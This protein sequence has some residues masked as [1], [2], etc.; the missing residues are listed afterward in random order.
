VTATV[1]AGACIDP[2]TIAAYV[3]GTL[4]PAEMREVEGHLADCDD[5]RELATGT[6][7]V[8]E[9]MDADDR[10]GATRRRQAWM[11]T[12]FLVLAAALAVVVVAPRLL[13]RLR[14]MPDSSALAAA[15]GAKRLT[16]GRLAGGFAY[17][18]L[19]GDTRAGD[20]PGVAPAEVIIAAARAE[21]ALARRKD[22]RSLTAYGA[23]QLLT[24]N[25]D[26][27]VAALEEAQA[28]DGSDVAVLIDL[29]SAYYEKSRRV[30]EDQARILLDKAMNAATEAT[31]LNLESPEA[32]FNR[33]LLQ[34][35]RGNV[36]DSMAAW[37][38]F[39]AVERDP[40][41]LEEG[42]RHLA[43]LERPRP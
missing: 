29:S 7:Q 11:S 33:A 34:E 19:V 37:R 42:R 35:K 26:R 25:V 12:G 6:A 39:L 9:A 13:D 1:R 17:G 38:R 20:G 31:R 21:Q 24:G 36:A 41:W 40:A 27:S 10:R 22:V 4:T 8:V 16:E 14:P 3:D 28:L 30:P 23:G 2:E 5:C 43:E 32:W 18:P 15:V